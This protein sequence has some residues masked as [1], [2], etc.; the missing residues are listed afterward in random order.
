MVLKGSQDS[1]SFQADR[2]PRFQEENPAAGYHRRMDIHALAVS[3][4]TSPLPDPMEAL[5]PHSMRP[6][7]ALLLEG[8]A[9]K[10]SSGD[11][12]AARELRE[13]LRLENDMT[14]PAP[15]SKVF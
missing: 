1:S 15:D 4:L 10:A 9:R 3:V 6:A 14:P 5:A 11:A 12:A 8:L 13:W 7:V 2:A